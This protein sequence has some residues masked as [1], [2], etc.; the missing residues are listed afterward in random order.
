[1]NEMNN[2]MPL[3]ALGAEGLKKQVLLRKKTCR[4]VKYRF[5]HRFFGQN[6]PFNEICLGTNQKQINVYN[7]IHVFLLF[8]RVFFIFST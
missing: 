8:S 3:S 5:C 7:K 1:M 4:Q 6:K 2:E